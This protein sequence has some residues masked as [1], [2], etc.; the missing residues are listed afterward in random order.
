MSGKSVF[1]SDRY[2][3][4]KDEETGSNAYKDVYAFDNRGSLKTLDK[5]DSFYDVV[6]G[7]LVFDNKNFLRK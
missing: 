6:K 5:V 1:K 7:S 2:F 4:R 3:F